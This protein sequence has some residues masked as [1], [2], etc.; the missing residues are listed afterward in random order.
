MVNQRVHFHLRQDIN[1]F[2]LNHIQKNI[3]L[4]YNEVLKAFLFSLVLCSCWFSKYGSKIK[5]G[6]Q[7]DAPVPKSNLSAFLLKLRTSKFILPLYLGILSN[8]CG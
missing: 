1:D 3:T 4:I 6:R 5:H 8:D 2:I 7:P